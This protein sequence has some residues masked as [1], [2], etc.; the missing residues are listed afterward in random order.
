MKLFRTIRI[1]GAALPLLVVSLAAK[2]LG[3]TTT[4]GAATFP[5]ATPER[6]ASLV[7]DPGDA[8]VVRRA[9]ALLA[10]DLERVT[11]R[12][13]SNDDT[14]G[15]RVLI[16][17]IGRSS[18]IDALIASG[19]LDVSSIRGRWEHFIVTRLPGADPVLVVAGSDRR[20]TA[21]GVMALSRAIGVSPWCPSRRAK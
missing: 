3:T 14:A 7:V 6:V 2:N 13:P 8:E 21:Y 20:G 17:T 12:R 15:P 5:L 1:L 19:R 16:G 11:G 9:A 4:P 18:T 10:D